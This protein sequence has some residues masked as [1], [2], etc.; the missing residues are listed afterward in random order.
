M[1]FVVAGGTLT[2]HCSGAADFQ[3]KKCIIKTNIDVKFTTS[4]L[5]T[6]EVAKIQRGNGVTN[7]S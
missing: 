2:S 4:L 5:F 3:S 6:S 7:V 1:L